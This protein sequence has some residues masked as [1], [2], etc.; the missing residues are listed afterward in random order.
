MEGGGNLGLAILGMV[1][2]GPEV[3][4]SFPQPLVFSLHPL[5]LGPRTPISPFSLQFFPRENI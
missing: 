1:R 3:A 4:L 5:C 2:Q